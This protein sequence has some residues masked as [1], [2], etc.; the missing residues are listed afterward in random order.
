MMSLLLGDSQDSMATLKEVEDVNP[1]ICSNNLPQ[2]ILS[3]GFSRETSMTSEAKMRK[4][5]FIPTSNGYATALA[6]LFGAVG[7]K[8]WNL[9][10][11]KLLGKNL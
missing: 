11:A 7:L 8:I 10:E 4:G 1:K 9:E 6:K 3:H 5:E 2:T